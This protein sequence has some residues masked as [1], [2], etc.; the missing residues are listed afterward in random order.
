MQFFKKLFGAQ[1]AP[2]P[3]ERFDIIAA[4]G[5]LLEFAQQKGCLDRQSNDGNYQSELKFKYFRSDVN[6]RETELKGKELETLFAATED[7]ITNGVLRI[8]TREYEPLEKL[9][10]ELKKIHVIHWYET[11]YS[12]ISI[13]FADLAD[14][15]PILRDEL[16][17]MADQSTLGAAGS[18]AGAEGDAN[19]SSAPVP[20]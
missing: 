20:N 17:K 10:N 4:A 9:C 6:G 3:A 1:K 2:Q 16:K 8:T 19:H 7:Q 18:A 11:R 12:D 15:A 5:L 13:A 14:G